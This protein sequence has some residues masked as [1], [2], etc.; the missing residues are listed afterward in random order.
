MA[1]SA[2]P[3]FPA[4]AGTF[5]GLDTTPLG[6]PGLV[7]SSDDDPYCTVDAARRLADAWGLDRIGVSRAGHINSASGLGRS[8]FG[9]ALL[10]AFT[11]G[12]R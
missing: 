12:A 1:D 5:T 6:V 2:G 8:D 7:V 4:E 3:A 10:T 11:A 9:R